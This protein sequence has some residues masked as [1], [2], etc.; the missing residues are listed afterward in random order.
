VL[1]PA[2]PSEPPSL[3]CDGPLLP[4]A[5]AVFEA[6]G[7]LAL[8]EHAPS[9]IAPATQKYPISQ[10]DFDPR[11]ALDAR[12]PID[13]AQPH[14]ASARGLRLQTLLSP[15][16]TDPGILPFAHFDGRKFELVAVVCARGLLLDSRSGVSCAGFCAL[17]ASR[18][19]PPKAETV[20]VATR[21]HQSTNQSNNSDVAS[22][23]SRAV[24]VHSRRAVM[25]SLPSDEN[26]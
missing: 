1:E 4:D 5:P 7:E 12:R 15:G 24:Y 8:P 21:D 9:A 6:E 17:R 26:C 14:P 23:S 13:A 19:A 16:G 10:S 11:I 22:C 20:Y 2:A 25:V 3:L 18:N